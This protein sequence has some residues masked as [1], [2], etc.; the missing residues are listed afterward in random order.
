MK[1]FVVRHEQHMLDAHVVYAAINHV[2]AILLAVWARFDFTVGLVDNEPPFFFTGF[3]RHKVE[4]VCDV[5][6]VKL[7]SLLSILLVDC[8]LVIK[9]P[10][11]AGA[12]GYNPDLLLSNTLSPKNV[13]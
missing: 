2:M 11:L 10:H 6:L 9:C 12:V 13:L 8:M 5:Q 7:V 4:N 1:H 3:S